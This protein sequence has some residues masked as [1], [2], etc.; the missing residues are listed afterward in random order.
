M[1]GRARRGMTM[2]EVSVVLAIIAVLAAMSWTSYERFSLRIGPQNAAAELSGALS[3]ARARAV[4][5]QADVWLIIY[6]DINASGQPNQGSGAWFLVEDRTHEFNDTNTPPS[7]HLRYSTFQPPAQIQP[8][9]EQGVLAASMYM[10]SYTKRSVRFGA[11][12]TLAWT[13]IFAGL[14]PS[15]CSFCTGTPR[16]GAIV[17]RGDGSARF[18]DGAG[19]PFT[20]AGVGTLQRAVSLG[21][22]SS[23]G[24]REFQFAV[25]GPVGFV[26]SRSR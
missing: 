11:S 7:G 14:T 6:P 26:D 21:L 19:N 2:L 13:G 17:F 4:D 12:G 8:A 1:S 9:P 5:R 24:Q 10:D 25:S 16:R 3:E 22:L 23:D 18:M 20:P 15:G